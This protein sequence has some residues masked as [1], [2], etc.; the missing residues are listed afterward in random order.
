MDCHR[1][2]QRWRIFIRLLSRAPF[3]VEG[4]LVLLV[5]VGIYRLMSASRQSMFGYEEEEVPQIG[6]VAGSLNR[7]HVLLA[8]ADADLRPVAVAIRSAIDSAADPRR[9]LFHYFTV[10]Q[11]A[12]VV[13]ELFAEQLGFAEVEVI[14]DV[15]LQ[16]RL[17]ALPSPDLA[18][19]AHR[20]AAFDLAPYFAHELLAK[21]ASSGI[22]RLI[23]LRTDT[24]VLGDLAELEQVDLGGSPIGMGRSCS[25][26]I[27]DVV[28]FSVREALPTKLDKDACAPSGAVLAIDML[29][30]RTARVT[31]RVEQL[32]RI[33]RDAMSAIF[34]AIGGRIADLG[35]EWAPC[36]GLARSA[37]TLREKE[38][39]RKM[40]VEWSDLRSL[41]RSHQGRTR[42]VACSRTA[43]LLL[44]DG[45]LKPWLPD[46]DETLDPA[47]ACSVPKSLSLLA[48]GWSVVVHFLCEGVPVVNCA[49]LWFSFIS[50]EAACAL[51][52]FD[53]EWQS[54]EVAWRRRRSELEREFR[55]DGDVAVDAAAF[56]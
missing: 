14:H 46:V 39:A 28:N 43:K 2:C 25:H 26:L 56:I 45:Q 49:D 21:S 1:R 31:D 55:V 4:L 52:D 47:P 17:E 29:A 37:A 22:R 24:V 33:H 6:S 30:W 13:Q 32:A 41:Q 7:I 40:G 15:A 42:I 36:V 27:R 16:E 44:F 35:G 3:R 8:S 20:A 5:L 48:W 51:K 10:P 53:A 23:Y 50:P 12:V 38:E 11:L 54:D 18:M 9:L 19:A 34:L